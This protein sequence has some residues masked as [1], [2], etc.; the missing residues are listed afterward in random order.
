LISNT[1]GIKDREV[2]KISARG[3]DRNKKCRVT[4]VMKAKRETSGRYSSGKSTR[5]VVNNGGEEVARPGKGNCEGAVIESN[6]GSYVR[7]REVERRFSRA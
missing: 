4:V 6:S 7:K 3:S 2:A 1:E 5:T